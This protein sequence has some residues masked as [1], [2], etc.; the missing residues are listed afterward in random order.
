MDRVCGGE[1]KKLKCGTLKMQTLSLATAEDLNIG[2]ES[3]QKKLYSTSCAISV[4]KVDFK[5]REEPQEKGK[6]LSRTSSPSRELE[7]GCKSANRGGTCAELLGDSGLLS[8]GRVESETG[9]WR[10]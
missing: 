10:Q 4:L 8:C 5:H 6:G 9:G 3:S 7:D 1:R 2:V